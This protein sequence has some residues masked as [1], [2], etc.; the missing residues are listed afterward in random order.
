MFDNK[1]FMV[2]NNGVLLHQMLKADLYGRT[3]LHLLANNQTICVG[4]AQAAEDILRIAPQWSQLAAILKRDRYGRTPLDYA[5]I[6][7]KKRIA[8]AIL[9]STAQLDQQMIHVLL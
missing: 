1:N 7:G 8:H 6:K 4:Y 3:P 9:Q 5:A 2:K